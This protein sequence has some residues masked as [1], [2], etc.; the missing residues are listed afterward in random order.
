MKLAQQ[1]IHPKTDSFFPGSAIRGY[2]DRYDCL[3][4]KT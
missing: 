1:E 2:P 4:R 3:R